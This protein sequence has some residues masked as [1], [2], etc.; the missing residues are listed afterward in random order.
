MRSVCTV[1]LGWPTVWADN[2]VASFAGKSRERREVRG[3]RRLSG[4]K[5]GRKKKVREEFWK[6]QH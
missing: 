3:I 2:G 5:L 4:W 1:A 6:R